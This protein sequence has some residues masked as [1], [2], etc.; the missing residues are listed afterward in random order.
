MQSDPQ[1]LFNGRT[2]RDLLLQFYQEKNPSKV[3]EVDKL[4]MKYRGNEEQM[5]RNLAKKYQL[6]VSVFGISPSSQAA[7]FGSPVATPAFGQASKMGGGSPFGQSPGGFGQT[8]S[9]GAGTGMSSST[10]T[11]QTFGSGST[12]GFGVSTFGSLAQSSS[13][14]GGQPSGFG[15][16]NSGFGAMPNAFGSPTPFGAARR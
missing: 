5:F 1:R 4:L 14:F 3:G 12:A 15:S 16:G 9:L 11:G 13:P 2:A 8:S 7:S 10:P 6:D